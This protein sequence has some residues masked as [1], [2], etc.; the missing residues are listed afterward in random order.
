LAACN[1]HMNKWSQQPSKPL[2]VWYIII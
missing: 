2:E 1:E